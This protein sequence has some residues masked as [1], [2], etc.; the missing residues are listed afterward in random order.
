MVELEEDCYVK[1]LGINWNVNTDEFRY[2]IIELLFYVNIFLDIK[3]LFLKF[4]VKF[5]DF[6][7][8]FTLFI[9]NMKVF[10]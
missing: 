4:V 5:F 7:G 2:D 6:M 9:I 1:F 3:R 8:L 10:F